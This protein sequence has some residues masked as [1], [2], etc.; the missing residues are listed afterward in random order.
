LSLIKKEKSLKNRI[1]RDKL[2]TITLGT[3][4]G[5]HFDAEDR[6]E[7]ERRKSGVTDNKFTSRMET[8]E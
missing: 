2:G 3:I 7:E 4:R 1:R 6:D 5:V 8:G